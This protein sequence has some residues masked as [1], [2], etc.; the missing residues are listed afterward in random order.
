VRTTAIF[1]PPGTG[2]T[3]ALLRILDDK[4]KAG[5]KPEEVAFVSFTRKAANEARDRALQKFPRFTAKSFKYFRTIHSV[6]LSTLQMGKASV[7]GPTQWERINHT[8][9]TA[10]AVTVKQQFFEGM[11]STGDLALFY[12]N[13]ARLEN[14]DWRSYYERIPVQRATKYDLTKA[15]YLRFGEVVEAYKNDRGLIDFTDM[16]ELALQGG[17][18]VPVKY[19]IIDEAQDLSPVQWKLL[20]VMFAGV[21]ELYMAGDDDQAI[22]RWSGA[23]VA[24][25]QRRAKACDDVRVLNKS[26]RL[27][28]SVWETA[29]RIINRVQGERQPKTWG[30]RDAKGRAQYFG[31]IKTVPVLDAG[32]WLLLARTK[33]HLVLYTRLLRDAA[34]AFTVHNRSNINHDV[35]RG[36]YAYNDLVFGK[37]IDAT[38][39]KCLYAI[40]R[41]EA[42]D[43]KERVLQSVDVDPHAKYSALW[44]HENLGLKHRPKTQFKTQC[45][46]HPHLELSDARRHTYYRYMRACKERG[47]DPFAMPRHHIDTIHGVKGGE[48]DH[49]VLLAD[50]TPTIMDEARTNPTVRDDEHRVFYV[51]ATRAKQ[52]LWIATDAL[53]SG[54]A[55][56]TGGLCSTN[57][58]TSSSKSSASSGAGT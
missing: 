44:L 40:L 29:N 18:R 9:G 27:P 10:L 7:L 1:G 21:A 32:S 43:T 11:L 20:D 31:D 26:W 30:P 17:K 55:Y 8:L 47:L 57:S 50:T 39:V 35:L 33:L 24:E 38:A 6:A 51:G 36:L 16:L 22:Y 3:T 4:F 45:T 12:Y 37:T 5:A 19:A 49:V 46:V 13:I 42:L 15:R 52:S 53:V 34:V 2:K 58:S 41:T 28:S 14:R 48:A 23:D 56:P 54:L 25:F